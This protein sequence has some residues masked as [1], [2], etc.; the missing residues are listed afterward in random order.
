MESALAI[1]ACLALKIFPAP[2]LSSSH[3]PLSKSSSTASSCTHR[4]L[5]HPYAVTVGEPLLDRVVVVT[6][7]GA[8][9]HPTARVH[10][11][12]HPPVHVFTTKIS[13]TFRSLADN[14]QCFAQIL[15][16]LSPPVYPPPPS[17]CRSR[18]SRA[19]A[20]LA[21]VTVAGNR[22][23]TSCVQCQGVAVPLREVST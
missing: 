5:S 4:R 20:Q 22:T 1:I 12:A 17:M 13:Q 15:L 16:S 18:R 19:S 21:R 6:G 11:Q 14:H 9:C 23:P 8:G 7:A 10:I 2:Q 3:R